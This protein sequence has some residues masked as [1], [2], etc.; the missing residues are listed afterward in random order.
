MEAYQ[1]D[2]YKVDNATSIRQYNVL[3]SNMAFYCALKRT[4]FGPV[5]S[6]RGG[7]AVGDVI[8]RSSEVHMRVVPM[9]RAGL[10]AKYH[11]TV[12]GQ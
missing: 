6:K 5:H 10:S 4:A 3:L 12:C 8:S 9:I 7:Q 1:Y 2:Q 11:G